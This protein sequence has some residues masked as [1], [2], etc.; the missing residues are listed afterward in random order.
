MN[1]DNFPAD[2]SFVIPCNGEKLLEIEH[3]SLIE[4]PQK[5]EFQYVLDD[6]PG[7]C[8]EVPLLKPNADH[9]KVKTIIDACNRVS[10]R[11]IA[12]INNV[13]GHLVPVG[14]VGVYE[15]NG[16]IKVGF[17]NPS[18]SYQPPWTINEGVM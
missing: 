13:F 18:S 9:S 15:H 1:C 8:P 7:F 5:Y 6:C 17:L 10:G 3:C 16:K 14:F 11:Q 2:G 4:G 12:T